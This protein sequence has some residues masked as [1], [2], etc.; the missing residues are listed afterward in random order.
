ME[1]RNGITLCH[2]STHIVFSDRM[3]KKKTTGAIK[4]DILIS[5]LCMDVCVYFCPFM[6]PMEFHVKLGTEFKGSLSRSVLGFQ[7]PTYPSIPSTVCDCRSN[8]SIDTKL[9][10][11]VP[12]ILEM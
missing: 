2:T 3:N 7:R 4:R 6:A 1:P 11:A 8:Q 12:E 9:V 5:G 10:K